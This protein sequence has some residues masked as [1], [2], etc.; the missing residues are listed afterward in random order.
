MIKAL[1]IRQ[2]WAWAI[3]QGLKPVENR[4][5]RTAYR[6]LLAIHASKTY[7]H[8]GHRYIEA[9]FGI[10]VPANLPRGALIGSVIVTECVDENGSGWFTGP[11]GFVM[12]E[13]QALPSDR[14]IHCNGKLGL[15]NIDIPWQEVRLDASPADAA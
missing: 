3:V 9:A 12:S 5:W 11:F 13:A 8:E 1:S 15:F 14:I 10:E 6:G 7:D 4:T 2:P